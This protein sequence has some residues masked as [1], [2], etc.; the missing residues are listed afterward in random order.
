MVVEARSDG[1]TIP[2]GQ[3]LAGGGTVDADGDHRIAMAAAIGAT[4]AASPVTIRGFASVPTSY[5][6]F[7]DHLAALGGRAEVSA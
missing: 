6:S 5:P 4:V 2:G 3:R 7:L 1:F